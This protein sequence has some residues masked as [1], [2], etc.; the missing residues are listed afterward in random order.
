MPA[1]RDWPRLGFRVDLSFLPLGG[2][3]NPDLRFSAEMRSK[4][5]KGMLPERFNH[6]GPVDAS[7]CHFE[8]TVELEA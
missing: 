2:I 3:Q 1:G 4:I 7:L 5:V 6:C 8:S